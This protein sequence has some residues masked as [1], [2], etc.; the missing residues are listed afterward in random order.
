MGQWGQEERAGSGSPGD[1]RA[2]EA[3]ETRP[4]AP[5]VGGSFG[6]WLSSTP[7]A[8]AA[9][10]V[11]IVGIGLLLYMVATPP[12]SPRASNGGAV[13]RGRTGDLRASALASAPSTSVPTTTTL[14]ATRTA[15]TSPAMTAPAH[16]APVVAAA[17]NKTSSA[18]VTGTTT[19]QPCSAS[20]VVI[21]TTTDNAAYQAGQAVQI[22]T[23]LTDVRACIY[24]PVD[25]GPYMC[26]VWI[27]VDN[28]GGGQAWPW[29]DQSE[30]CSAPAATTLE[31]GATESVRTTWNGQVS[32]GGAAAQAPPGS[33]VAHGTWAWST[34]AGTPPKIVDAPSAPFTIV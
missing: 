22:V 23:T 15:P 20:D 12:A 2:E 29:P 30:V 4:A 27:V 28:P 16:A 9:A 5:A 21:T 6:A 14:P 1:R 31:P 8:L 25:S 13:P 24:R 26:P 7:S 32:Q 17:N 11:M 10:V 33:Y 34:G 19:L 18:P 3:E